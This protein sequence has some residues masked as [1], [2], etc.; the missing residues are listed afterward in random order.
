[1]RKLAGFS[2]IELMIV[3]V[4]VAILAAVAVPSYQNYI[5]RTNRADAKSTLTQIAAA[6]ERYFFSNNEYAVDDSA[7][8]SFEDIYGSS[9]TSEGHYNIAVS[10]PCGDNTCF[11]ITATAT[12]QQASDS[13]C[14]TFTINHVGQK[15]SKDSSDNVTTDDCW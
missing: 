6:Q 13:A 15:A 4:I 11:T 5:L 1:M 14:A 3:V 10:N 7:G 2:L 9:T 8:G 12:G